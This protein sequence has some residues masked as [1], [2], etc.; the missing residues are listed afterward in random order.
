MPCKKG[1]NGEKG[2]NNSTGRFEGGKRALA[3]NGPLQL[4]EEEET[5]ISGKDISGRQR[6]MRPGRRKRETRF[7][8]SSVN[9]MVECGQKSKRQPAWVLLAERLKKEDK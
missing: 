7:G 2:G 6:R 1:G 9:H 5:L 8:P 3:T 4:V